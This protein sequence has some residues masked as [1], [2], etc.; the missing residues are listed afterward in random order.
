MRCGARGTG[1]GALESA[2]RART[3]A[4]TVEV[5]WNFVGDNR[6]KDAL[7]WSVTC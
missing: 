5:A 6:R 3:R 2:R 1:V 4:L 7:L